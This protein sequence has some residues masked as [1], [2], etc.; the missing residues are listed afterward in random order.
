MPDTLI[1]RSVLDWRKFGVVVFEISQICVA[2][3]FFAVLD[4][5]GLIDLNRES[6]AG[7]RI[8][9][10]SALASELA[11]AFARGYEPNRSSR[12]LANGGCGGTTFG[13]G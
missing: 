11:D 6:R 9:A 7:A 12:S 13:T 1:P 2:E 8:L 10:R 5:I 4:N 3:S